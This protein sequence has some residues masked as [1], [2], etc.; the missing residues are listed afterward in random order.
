MYQV[1]EWKKSERSGNGGNCVE[2]ARFETSA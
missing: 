2:V 1:T